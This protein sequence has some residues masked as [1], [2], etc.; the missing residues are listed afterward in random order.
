MQKEIQ[1]LK[2]LPTTADYDSLGMAQL[3]QG[4]SLMRQADQ[5]IA[6][7]PDEVLDTLVNIEN[8]YLKAFDIYK[9]ALSYEGQMGDIVVRELKEKKEKA[10]ND[11]DR[12]YKVL[13]DNAASLKGY[14][15]DDI[16]NNY[17]RR[18]ASIKACLKE[19]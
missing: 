2:A 18:A 3:N 19:D 4:N 6:E 13:K 11:L 1:N 16:M 9:M 15:I 7:H 8:K 5:F 17:E 12:L 14:G 10:R